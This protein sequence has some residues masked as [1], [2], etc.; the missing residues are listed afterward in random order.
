MGQRGFKFCR[1]LLTPDADQGI[2][3]VVRGGMGQVARLVPCVVTDGRHHFI[4][5]MMT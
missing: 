2:E 3:I 1:F 4:S 5:V